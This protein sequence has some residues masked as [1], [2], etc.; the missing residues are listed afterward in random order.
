MLHKRGAIK[1]TA[2]RKL[3]A[4]KSFVRWL[5]SEEIITDDTFQKLITIKRPKMPD[6][7]PD[8]PSKEEMAVLLDGGVFPTAFPERDKLLCELMYGSAHQVRRFAARTERNPDQW[9]RRPLR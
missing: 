6:T 4:V 1:I 9:E 3:S 8:V 5:A 7:L 2:S